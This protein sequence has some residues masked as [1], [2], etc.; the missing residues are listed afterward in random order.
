MT[1][2]QPDKGF[3]AGLAGIR[4]AIG[5]PMIK[6]ITIEAIDLNKLPWVLPK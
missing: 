4:M 2:F 3:R 1:V 6:N 5:L